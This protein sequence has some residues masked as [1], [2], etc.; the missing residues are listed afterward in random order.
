MKATRL[1]TKDDGK[2]AFV[3]FDIE[4]EDSGDI[5]HL[6][7]IYPVTGIIFRETDEDYDYGWHNA[8]QRQFI[9]M[10][11]GGVDITSGE[12]ET[13]RFKAGDILLVEDTTGDG[14]I[15]RAVDGK[16]RKSVFIILE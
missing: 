3:D 5:G 9:L 13:R 11:E 10:L 15:S 8:P 14:H 2:S 16:R 1:Y 12:N 4:L 7:K 6:S